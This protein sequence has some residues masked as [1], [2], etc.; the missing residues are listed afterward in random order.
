MF[1]PRKVDCPAGAWTT[2][3]STSFAQLPK[4]WSV[5]FEGDVA[6]EYEE[7][8]SSWL[9]PGTPR[10]GPLAPELTFERGYLNTFFRVMV[11]P[12]RDVVAIID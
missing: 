11:R 12:E 9:F 10:R 5:R 3:I 6:G 7:K 8:K 1:G 4:S 2:I